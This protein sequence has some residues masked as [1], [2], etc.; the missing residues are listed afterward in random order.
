MKSAEIRKVIELY[1][2]GIPVSKIEELIDCGD[3]TSVE[4]L[5]EELV[6]T[7]VG[8]YNSG[9]SLSSI[10]VKVGLSREAIKKHLTRCNIEIR[11]KHRNM[12]DALDSEIIYL[13]NIEELGVTKIADR[14]EVG[15]RFVRDRLKKNNI[16][17]VDSRNNKTKDET[18]NKIYD[19]YD[20]GVHPMYIASELLVSRR[21]VEKYIKNR[22]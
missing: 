11:N 14:L 6:S 17:I 2:N 19:M 10:S 8:L 20:N 18:I 15:Y 22:E 21:T 13:H 7:I 1:T 12:G 4:N 16:D 9:E 5:R 3:T